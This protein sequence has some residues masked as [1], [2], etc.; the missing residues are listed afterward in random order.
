MKEIEGEQAH[1]ICD[2]AVDR[3]PVNVRLRRSLFNN[4]L[5]QL[6]HKLVS[7]RC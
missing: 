3:S 7:E 1:Q 6:L 4:G 2:P 5:D